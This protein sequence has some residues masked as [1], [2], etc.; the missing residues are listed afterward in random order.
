MDFLELLGEK[1]KQA[2]RYYA[3]TGIKMSFPVFIALMSAASI[4]AAA[5]TVSALQLLPE[6]FKGEFFLPFVAFVAVL[7]LAIGVPIHIRSSRIEQVEQALPDA[8]KHMAAVLR[9][10]GTTEAALEEVAL[11]DYGPLSADLSEALRTLREGKSF[12][13]ALSDTALNSGSQLFQRTT[14]IMLDARKA[15]AGLADVMEAIADDSRDYVRIRRERKSRTTMHVAFLYLTSLFLAPFIFGFTLSIIKFIGAGLASAGTGG[16]S[17]IG[18]QIAGEIDFTKFDIML[19]FFLT[20]QI[21]A[22]AMAIGVIRDGNY[23][24]NFLYLGAMLF[25]SLAVYVAGGVIGTLIIATGK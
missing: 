23:F 13:D 18:S 1:Y 20:A 12:D 8:L 15:G 2:E 9:A 25:V 19:K 4:V 10:G 11:S 5:A 6:D 14:A 3:A 21:V 7:S 16:V 22:S 24:K 17:V